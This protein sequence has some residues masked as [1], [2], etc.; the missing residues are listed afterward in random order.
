MDKNNKGQRKLGD[1]VGG[2]LPAVKGHSLELNRIEYAWVTV[3]M[4][5]CTQNLTVHA[6]RRML[7]LHHACLI[8]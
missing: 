8:T 1:S 6:G 2:L 4:T 7:F 5:V 3:G